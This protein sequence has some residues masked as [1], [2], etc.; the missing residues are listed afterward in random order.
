MSWTFALQDAENAVLKVRPACRWELGSN[1]N[2]H[3][4]SQPNF[5][6]ELFNS[7]VY[8]IAFPAFY[9]TRNPGISYCISPSQNEI[10]RSI[11]VWQATDA[12][13]KAEEIDETLLMKDI[14]N[15]EWPPAFEK[16]RHW[17]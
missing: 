11:S 3:A 6:L 12:V 17:A 10:R 7:D 15:F 16:K 9:P 13:P 8:S 14:L 2:N 4:R 1:K 5:D